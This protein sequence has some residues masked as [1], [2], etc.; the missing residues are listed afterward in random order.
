MV[1][2]LQKNNQ[3]IQMLRFFKASNQKD[4]SEERE[5]KEGFGEENDV[6]EESSE[7]VEEFPL[8]I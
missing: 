2:A 8:F 7:K 6:I 1:P 3:M 5:M 4:P